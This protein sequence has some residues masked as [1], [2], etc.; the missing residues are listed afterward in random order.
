MNATVS[1]PD[2]VTDADVELL[3]QVPGDYINNRVNGLISE[4]I[5]DY[6]HY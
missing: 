5:V 4:R 6:G 2:L 3:R 1:K